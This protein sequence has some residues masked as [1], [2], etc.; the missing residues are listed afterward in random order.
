MRTFPKAPVF[1]FLH[2]ETQPPPQPAYCTHVKA[3]LKVNRAS[4]FFQQEAFHPY[5]GPNLQTD[6]GCIT[7]TP[8]SAIQMSHPPRNPNPA[9]AGYNRHN[10]YCDVKYLGTGDPSSLLTLERLLPPIRRRRS[11]AVVERAFVCGY[12]GCHLKFC[13]KKN[14]LRHQTY[15]HGRNKTK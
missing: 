14:M 7:T 10:S 1:V 6:I 8:S 2:A 13:F 3:S 15:K 9:D 12:P 5:A 11:T 4:V